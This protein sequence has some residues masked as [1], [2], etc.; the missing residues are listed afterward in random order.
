MCTYPVL[1]KGFYNKNN[2]SGILLSFLIGIVAYFLGKQFPIIGAPV[3]AIVIGI[4]LAF[5]K[6]PTHFDSGIKVTGKKLLQAAIVLLGFEMNLEIV[7]AV[8]NQS[9]LIMVFTLVSCFVTGY[10]ISKALKIENKIATLVTVGTCICGGSA[11]AATAPVIEADD[12]EIAVSISTI[13]LFNILAVFIF[14]PLGHLLQMTDT[15]FGI[16]AG[17]AINDTSSVVAAAYSFS[18]EAGVLAT[19]V[20]L[21]RT[22]L[23]IP[24][25]FILALIVAK[26]K[27]ASSNNFSIKKVFPWFVIGFILACIVNTIGIL[28]SNVATFMGDGGKFFIAVAMAAIGL[29]TNLKHLLTNSRKPLLLGSC[30]WFVV[31]VVSLIVQNMMGLI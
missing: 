15:G 23:I 7:L 25:T 9:L 31:S 22:L 11:I 16:W 14:P 30:C 21:T 29:G 6:R 20:K 4:V 8:G 27:G 19:I 26:Q 24:I 2:V 3:F 1:G 5:W 18:E 28:P 12:S 10:L 13:F 17:T